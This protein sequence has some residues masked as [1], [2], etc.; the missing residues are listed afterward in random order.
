MTLYDI[1]KS[2]TENAVP[3]RGGC[4]PDAIIDAFEKLVPQLAGAQ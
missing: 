1:R 4:D 3:Y 2:T